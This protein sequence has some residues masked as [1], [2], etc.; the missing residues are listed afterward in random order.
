MV[1]VKNSD[2]MISR[3]KKNLS[4][5]LRFAISTPLN[6]VYKRA[7]VLKCSN[8]IVGFCRF[9]WNLIFFFTFVVVAHCQCEQ[10]YKLFIYERQPSNEN[11]Q[12]ALDIEYIS[13][14]YWIEIMFWMQGSDFEFQ[15]KI[16][17][18]IRCISTT[19]LVWKK[20]TNNFFVNRYS[21]SS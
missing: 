11:G 1:R 18:I 9:F 19:E 10:M 3:E 8:S 13:I 17:N 14:S 4:E 21:V 12:W 15:S 2:F 16:E 7:D 5:I 6:I 20:M